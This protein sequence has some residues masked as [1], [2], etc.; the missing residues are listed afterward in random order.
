VAEILNGGSSALFAF[1]LLL[2]A[3]DAPL[4]L[5]VLLLRMMMPT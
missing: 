1:I 2:T 4:V 5:S 3:F